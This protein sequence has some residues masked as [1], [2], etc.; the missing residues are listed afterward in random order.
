MA[1]RPKK[2]SRTSAAKNRKTPLPKDKL[3]SRLS[4]FFFDRPRVT[5]FL[6]ILL[7]L[8]GALSYGTFLRREGFP[9]VNFPLAFVNGTYFVNDPG[10]VDNDVARVISELAREQDGVTMVQTQSSANFFSVQISYDED[11]NAA[12]AT[13]ELEERVRQSG[14]LPERVMAQY[15]VPYFGATGG[16]VEKLDIALSFFT[17]D[18]SVSVQELAEQ[19]EAY[20]AVLRDRD[21]ANVEEVFVKSPFEETVN[22]ATGQAVTVRRS[23]D[24]FGSR[25]DEDSDYHASVII[26]IAARPGFD[27][28]ELDEAVRHALE[29]T[30][31]DPSLE[32]YGVRVSA[33]FAPGIE[34][35]ISELQRSLLEGLIAVL[36]VGSL[37]IAVRASIVTVIAMVTV[38]AITLGLLYS[39]GYTLNVITLFSL[40][41]ALALIVDDTIIMVEAIDAA[42]HHHKD[43]RRAVREATRKVS[44]AMVA[45]TATASLSFAPLLFVG[46]ILGTFIRAI[47]ITIISS[48]VISLFVAL[49]FIPFFARFLLLGPKQMGKKGVTE[50]ASGL[51]DKVATFVT[52]PMLWARR[53][54]KKLFLVG[55]TAVLIGMGFIGAGA[56]IARDVA[57]NIFP[58][59]KDTNGLVLRINFPPDLTIEQAEATAAEVDRIVAEELGENFVQ[60]SYFGSGSA[61]GASQQIDIISYASRDETS[62]QLVDR[63]QERFD[64]ELETARV[65][66]GQVDVGPPA[67]NFVVQIAA[68][69]REAAFRA[70][71]DVRAFMEDTQLQRPNGSKA[72]FV[73]VNVSSPNQYIRDDARPIVTVTAGFDGDDTSTLVALGDTALKNEFNETRMA[74][75]GLGAEDIRVDLGFESENQESFATLALAFPVL[76][77]VMYVL[78]TVQFR[79]F[80][81]PLLIFMAI[82]FSLFGITLGLKLSENAF[83]FFAMLGFFALVGLSVKNTILLTDYANQARRMGVGV[84]DSAVEAL[85]ERFRPLLATSATAVVSLIPLAITS[86]FWEGLTVVL[87]FGLLSSTFLVVTVFPYYYLGA[88]YLRT[89]IRTR[90]FLIWAAVVVAVSVLAG[91]WLGWGAALLV[92]VFGLLAIPLQR[93]WA[94][95]LA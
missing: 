86:P 22:P 71:E 52:R 26:G 9:S 59:T 25:E 87:I 32:G 37:V 20:A 49:V 67:S 12:A 84:V 61:Q 68:D 45:A 13:D 5:A 23:F 76:L 85:R 38:L 89:H 66:V 41:L 30:A 36:V 60:G 15:D 43:R 33:S 91:W 39:I 77:A 83:S 75:Y 31:D 8:F 92:P 82:P 16:D 27:V 69:D 35:Q 62:H 88:E 24:R 64:S 57:F 70:A 93:F 55:S 14:R 94:R 95:R 34:E 4:V 78:L 40:I 44:R 46:G 50:V 79:S 65:A 7:T 29:E 21:I 48:L 28:I 10:K 2:V 81:Q 53:S 58:P 18:D 17:R 6:W 3:L 63:L 42:R 73:N 19:A 51:E 1:A 80:L 72:R 56:L 74:Q 47:P 90:D 54:Q 11:V